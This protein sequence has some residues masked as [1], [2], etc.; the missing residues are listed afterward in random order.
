MIEAATS[1]LS[2]N[3][4]TVKKNTCIIIFAKYPA[5]DM[6][7]TRLQP[8]LGIDGS[9]RMAR[10]LLLHSIEQ[11]VA[12]GFT[13]ELCVSPAPT[14]PCWQGL[15]LPKNLQWSAQAQGDL[16]TRLLTASQNALENSD[17]VLLIGSDCPALTA[18]RMQRAAQQLNQ[19]DTVMIPAFDGGYVLLGLKQAD[20]S[21]F[22]SIMW[23]TNSVAAVTQ[24]RIAALDWTL[25]LLN[26]LADIDDPTDLKHLPVGWLDSYQV[27]D[28]VEV[29][30]AIGMA[31]KS[32]NNPL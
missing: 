27:A 28:V 15:D 10:Q 2:T 11:A 21:L 5:Q 4:Q 24:Q 31:D 12:S 7:K 16:G 32:I 29:T 18:E 6:A 20:E 9:A 25:A 8:A 23:S 17:K 3:Q 19:H 22:S 26:P 13:V 14:D 30:E 1:I